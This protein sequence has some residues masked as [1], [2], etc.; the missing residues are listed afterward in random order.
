M[1]LVTKFLMDMVLTHG[2]GSAR[3][4]KHAAHM[5]T[6]R[7][8]DIFSSCPK[9][10]EV[11]FDLFCLSIYV[12]MYCVGTFMLEGEKQP[13]ND[14]SIMSWLCVAMCPKCKLYLKY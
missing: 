10:F 14:A 8:C 3:E 2:Q 1:T 4:R 13:Y 12:H 6:C 7:K 11:I 9:V 5:N